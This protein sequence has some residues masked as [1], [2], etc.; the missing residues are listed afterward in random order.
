MGEQHTTVKREIEKHPYVCRLA[1]RLEWYNPGSTLHD[2]E[3]ELKMSLD[4]VDGLISRYGET[5]KLTDTTTPAIE[6]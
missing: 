3:D 6:K 4:V 2:L 5:V 1:S